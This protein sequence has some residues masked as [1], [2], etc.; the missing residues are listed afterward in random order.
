MRKYLLLIFVLSL[1]FGAQ[2]VGAQEKF[3]SPP[4]SPRD[5]KIHFRVK[6]EGEIIPG[7]SQVSAL[8]RKTEVLEHRGGGDPSL[9]R[10]SPGKTE[11]TPI[12]LKRPRSKDKEFER[13]ANKVWS[14]GA[15][16]GSEVSLRDYRKDV[17]VELSDDRGRVLMAF[18]V[19]RCWPSEYVAMSDLNLEDRSLATETLVL[20]H[21][22]WERDDT[23][24]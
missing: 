16:L 13:W 6:W 17:L 3:V 24:P 4:E 2:R 11:Y 5:V 18:K 22:G 10:R 1:G 7:I 12:I 20:Q 21:E 8:R 19:F 23:I 14:L 9:M 15:G